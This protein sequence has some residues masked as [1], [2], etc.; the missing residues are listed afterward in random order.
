VENLNQVLQLLEITYFY[1]LEFSELLRLRTDK[2]AQNHIDNP[3][4]DYN[5]Y[6]SFSFPF[7]F[8]SYP[9]NAGI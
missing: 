8:M 6:T 3:M 1:F 4:D 2:V 9:T 5:H 7:G